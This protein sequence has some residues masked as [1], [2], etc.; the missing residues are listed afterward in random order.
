MQKNY[1][2]WTLA[3]E[4][5]YSYNPD[6]DER[7]P[8]KAASAIEKLS[9]PQRSVNAGYSFQIY[10]QSLRPADDNSNTNNMLT[11]QGLALMKEMETKLA[12]STDWTQ[13]CLLANTTT[14]TT[15]NDYAWRCVDPVSIVSNKKA[16]LLLAPLLQ[17]LHSTS[18]SSIKSTVVNTFDPASNISSAVRS[19]WKFGLPIDPSYSTALDNEKEQKDIVRK[20]YIRNKMAKTAESIANTLSFA[21]FKICTIECDPKIHSY[22]ILFDYSG[23]SGQW[24][25]RQLSADGPLAGLSFAFVLIVM[26][27]HTRSFAI[28]SVGSKCISALCSIFS[29]TTIELTISFSCLFVSVLQCFKFSCL[30][31]LHTSFTVLFS[32]Y[33]ILVPC[34]YL[35]SM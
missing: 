7:R 5:T 27:I 20:E 24:A 13:H 22:R 31:R 26:T 15:T 11:T 12:S 28:A 21:D 10:Y 25:M 2:A 6:L 23:L 8:K 32:T 17:W 16:P 35:L 4:A 30:F 9:D 18:T 34:K 19:T 29:R 3:E 1:D 33:I 14:T